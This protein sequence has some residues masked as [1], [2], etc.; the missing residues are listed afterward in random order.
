MSSKI[1]YLILLSAVLLH[2][3]CTFLQ[4]VDARRPPRDYGQLLPAGG[5]KKPKRGGRFRDDDI[6]DSETEKA[7]ATNNAFEWSTSSK[8]A[9]EEKDYENEG[10]KDVGD[11]EI[12]SGSNRSNGLP[13]L[14]LSN[15]RQRSNGKRSLK[16]QIWKQY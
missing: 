9:A 2:I 15:E 6:D 16:R 11:D 12:D 10:E 8:K 3:I 5:T 14:Q 13:Q 1:Q 4:E 7:S